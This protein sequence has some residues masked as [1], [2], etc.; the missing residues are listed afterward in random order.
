M[1]TNSIKIVISDIND[2]TPTII[3]KIDIPFFFLEGAIVYDCFTNFFL[4]SFFSSTG[5]F[6]PKFQPTGNNDICFLGFLP[7]FLPVPVPLVL[8]FFLGSFS[9]FSSFA[10]SSSYFCASVFVYFL[11]V[12][13]SSVSKRSFKI[14]SSPLQLYTA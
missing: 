13:R 12:I 1:A 10:F 8:F 5:A 7:R 14:F 3:Q 11:P 9:W 2:D 4:G 6:L